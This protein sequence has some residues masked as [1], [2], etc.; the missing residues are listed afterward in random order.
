MSAFADCGGA[1]TVIPL[2]IFL[3]MRPASSPDAPRLF[4]SME[5]APVVRRCSESKII[6]VRQD[7]HK[8]RV[9]EYVR[10]D[11]DLLEQQRPQLGSIAAVTNV[12][13]RERPALRGCYVVISGAATDV[14]EACRMVQELAAV[15]VVEESAAKPKLSVPPGLCSPD[16]PQHIEVTADCS[17]RDTA[18]VQD[19]TVGTASRPFAPVVPLLTFESAAVEP[20]KVKEHPSRAFAWEKPLPILVPLEK[21]AITGSHDIHSVALICSTQSTSLSEKAH[22]G[23]TALLSTRL[24]AWTTVPSKKPKKLIADQGENAL[25]L[26]HPL[27]QCAR[28]RPKHVKIT[29]GGY[30][31]SRNPASGPRWA[32]R[33]VEQIMSLSSA[34]DDSVDT[35]LACYMWDRSGARPNSDHCQPVRQWRQVSSYWGARV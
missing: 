34:Q 20:T 11:V 26:S 3:G 21:P 12:S 17:Q 4:H 24:Q 15:D 1:E 14:A 18:I 2:A 35:D 5:V 19:I 8:R 32:E 31:R 25:G 33:P 22:N 13:L 9:S 27:P 16:P 28:P 6:K 10:V 30:E 7:H 23:N 29:A